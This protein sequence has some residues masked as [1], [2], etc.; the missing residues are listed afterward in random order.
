LSTSIVLN[1]YSI[2]LISAHKLHNICNYSKI[3]PSV[4]F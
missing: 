2:D 4:S 1:T 3:H